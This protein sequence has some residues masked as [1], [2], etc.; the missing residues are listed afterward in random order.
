[1]PAIPAENTA[2]PM[3]TLVVDDDPLSRKLLVRSLEKEGFDV[4]ECRDGIEAMQV[5][6]SGGPAML[7]LDYQMPEFNGAQ[8]CELIR[9]DPNPA[10]AQVPIL[11]LTAHSNVDHEIECLRAG[12]N[13]FVTKPVNTAVLKARIDTHQRLYQLREQLV[14]QNAEL[15]KWRHNHELDLDAARLTQQAI[16]PHRAPLLTGWDFAMH[17]HP[18]IQIGGDIYDWVKTKDGRLLVWISDATGHGAAAALLT[19]LS[20]LVFR[21]AAVETSA[22]A[23]EVMQRVDADYRTI[24]K[25]RSFMTAA[26]LA[27]APES[28]AISFCG[29]GHPPLLIARAG[30]RVDELPSSS[31]PLGLNHETLC[32]PHPNAELEKGDALLLYTDGLY[33]VANPEGERLSEPALR[34]LLPP[35]NGSAK[36]WLAEILKKVTAHTRGLPFPDDIAVIAA[37]RKR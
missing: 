12:A 5:L 2:H 9:S 23:D 35:A 14:A 32:S 25:H 17:Y 31:P 3:K 30:G 10:I 11:M 4:I 8:V 19:T 21:H 20:K 15:E 16:L 26:V 36:E 33:E 29:A 27:L 34:N 6:E 22:S 13:D 7:V 37:V 18:H 28:G 1:M 24:F